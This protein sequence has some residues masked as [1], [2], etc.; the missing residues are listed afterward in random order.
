MISTKLEN[1]L[2]DQL[3]KELYSAY[4]YLSIEAY[5]TSLNLAGFAHWFHVQVQEERD[6]A[7]IFFNYIS[8]VGGRV[9]L[10][11]IDAPQ[12]D[13][14]SIGEALELTLKHEQF[15]TQ[16][17]YDIVDQAISERDHKTNSFLQW[18]VTEQVEEEENATMNIGKFN[19]V[20]DD[21][22][23]IMM[24]DTE[25][26]GRVYVQAAPLAATGAAG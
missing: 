14:S 18:F 10:Q 8:K 1:M 23:G 19:L 15:V 22:K 11:A 26:A 21:G 16:S 5:F 2:N 3:N 20:K 17:I 12:V 9:K 4:L 6:H 13:F 25:L 7:L 24:L